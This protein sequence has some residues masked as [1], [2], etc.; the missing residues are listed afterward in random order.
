MKSLRLTTLL[1]TA[2]TS[3]ACCFAVPPAPSSD[4]KAQIR[5]L[6]KAN[7][8]LSGHLV[9]AVDTRTIAAVRSETSTADI[10]HLVSLLGDKDHVV[11]IGASLAL[12]DMGAPALPQIIAATQ[13]TDPRV[14][15]LAR[16]LLAQ[17]ET[18]QS[19]KQP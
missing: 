12:Q 9:C 16:D 1:L 19:I 18:A 11:G 4:R 7:L 14:R 2:L 10:P 17:L 6:I 15:M 8:H 5:Y 3:F 13:S